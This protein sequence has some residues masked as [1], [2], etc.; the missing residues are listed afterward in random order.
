MG[1][2]KRAHSPAKIE[3]TKLTSGFLSKFKAKSRFFNAKN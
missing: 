3:E 2:G 1:V